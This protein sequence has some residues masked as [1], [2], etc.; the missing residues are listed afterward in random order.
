MREQDT[1]KFQTARL[2]KLVAERAS[3]KKISFDESRTTIRFRI[4][5]PAT[6]VELVEAK[7]EWF[8]DELADKS[9]DELW[10]MIVHL[11]NGKL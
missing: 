1:Y 7:G 4:M 3:G 11:S 2:K 6:H 10:A 9:D 5:D 8:P